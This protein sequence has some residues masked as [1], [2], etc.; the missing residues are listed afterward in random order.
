MLLRVAARPVTL[1]NY[2]DFEQQF[3]PVQTYEVNGSMKNTF[4]KEPKIREMGARKIGSVLAAILLGSVAAG[5]SVEDAV[6]QTASSFQACGSLNKVLGVFGPFDYNDPEDR[7]Q[8]LYAVESFH[9][10][11]EVEELRAGKSGTVA[12]DLNYTLI[13]FPNHHRALNSIARLESSKGD[14]SGAKYS[15]DCY[16][17]RAMR[18]RPNDAAVRG[19]YANYLY[20]KNDLAGARLQYEEALRLSPTAPELCYNA[21][22]FFFA[23]KDYARARALAKVAYAG[24]YPLPGLRSKLQAAGAW[25]EP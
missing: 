1:F 20:R 25:S 15:V 2:G 11:Q 13:S 4:G 23:L 3:R 12:A 19:I 22:L 17:D 6:G 24:G 16:F 21:G 10:T 7:S 5:A 18:W 8:R 14:M 9:F